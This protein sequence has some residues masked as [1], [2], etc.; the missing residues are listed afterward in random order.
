MESSSLYL[1]E[2]ETNLLRQDIQHSNEYMKFYKMIN[3]GLHLYNVWIV[4]NT[5]TSDCSV[6]FVYEKLW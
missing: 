6:R 2:K 1:S 5:D 3:D 4:E